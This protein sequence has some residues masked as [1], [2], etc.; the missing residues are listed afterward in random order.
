MVVMV[1]MVEMVVF[2]DRRRPSCEASVPE[3]RCGSG[4]WTTASRRF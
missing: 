2:D 4:S 1:E 3:R